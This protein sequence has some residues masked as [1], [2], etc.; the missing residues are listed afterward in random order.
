GNQVTAEYDEES[1]NLSTA[2]PARKEADANTYDQYGN[3]TASTEPGAPTYNMLQNGSFEWKDAAGRPEF[4]Y[5]GGDTNAISIDGSVSLYGK[6]SAKVSSKKATT[7]YLTSHSQGVTPGQKLTLNV[8]VRMDNVAGTPGSS[9]VGIGL[10]YYDANGNY[11]GSSYSPAS[12]GSGNLDLQVTSDAPA[13]ASRMFTGLILWNAKGTVWFDGAQ[14]ESPVKSDEGHILTRFDYVE[15]SSFEMASSYWYAGGDG[16]TTVS[17][18]SPWAGAYSAKINLTT[19]GTAWIRSSDISVRAGEPLTL[20]GFVKTVD[21]AGTGARVQ[22]QYYDVNNNYL[23]FQATEYQT[24]TKDYTRYAIAATPP[25]GTNRAIVFGAVF[26]STGIAYFDNLKLVPRSTTRYEYDAN[27]NYITGITNSLGNRT[28]F[29]YDTVGD[30]TQ[31][32]DPKGNVTSFSYDALNNLTSVTDALGKVSR[33]EY[34]PVSMQVVYRDARSSGPEDNTYKTSLRYNELNQLI[35]ITDPRGREMTNTYDDAANLASTTFP[36][37]KQVLHTYDAAN[38]LSQKSYSSD[39]TTYSFSYDSAGNISQVQDNSS[40]S[41]QYTYDKANRLTSATD[42]FSYLLNYTMD[43][44]GNITTVTDSNN[45][46][47]SYAY[48]SANQ[49][50]ALTDPSGRQTRFRYDEAGRLF[51]TIKGNGYKASNSYDEVGRV[52]QISDPGNPNGK[53]LSYIYDANGN[54][55]IASGAGGV[56][57]FAYDAIN[58]LTSWTSDTGTVTTYTYD[59][60]GNLTKKGSKTYTYNAANEI[61]NAG[62]TYDANGNLTSDGTFNYQYNSENQL[63]R[64]TRVSDGTEVATYEYDYRGLRVAKTTPSGTV[65]EIG[66]KY[67]HLVKL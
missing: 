46:T 19:S 53:G 60:V 2:N 21:I 62:F 29:A 31:A 54:I 1:N 17:N 50:L 9:G 32:T 33:Y 15:N 63:T 65:T 24:G 26:S 59:A 44:A 48:G 55:T 20:S 49:L 57:R 18:E 4:W 40:R 13:N 52:K 16:E 7:A 5:L 66:T 39:P 11:L 36:N 22:V 6:F 3:V 23:G 28:T 14:L 41:Y 35:G 67:I 42:I 45:K 38:R 51:Q 10:E 47:V 27:A 56:E 43:S 37:G 30:R 34:D 8:P 61:T 64:V 58:R 12:V 25:A